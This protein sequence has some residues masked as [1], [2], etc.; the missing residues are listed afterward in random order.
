MN[1]YIFKLLTKH[2][3]IVSEIYRDDE[4][5]EDFNDNMLLKYNYFWHLETLEF[6]ETES[7]NKVYELNVFGSVDIKPS[8]STYNVYKNYN[9]EL[10]ITSTID[11]INR[12]RCTMKEFMLAEK[13]GNYLQLNWNNKN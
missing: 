5:L 8:M 9:G 2:N 12:C 13:S 4:N 6:Q 3:G 11:G 7:I 10:S 1:Y